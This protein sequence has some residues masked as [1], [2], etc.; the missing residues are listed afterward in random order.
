MQILRD[1]HTDTERQTYRQACRQ[2]GRQAD[3]QTGRQTEGETD[4]DQFLTISKVPID[5]LPLWPKLPFPVLSHSNEGKTAHKKVFVL[6]P[7]LG[8][9][10][11]GKAN[12]QDD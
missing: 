4:R 2:G 5:L 9:V 7:L 8:D 12:T 1:R 10:T 3:R 6:L 11:D